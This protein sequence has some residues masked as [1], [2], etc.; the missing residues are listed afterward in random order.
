MSKTICKY[1]RSERI[2]SIAG[3]C[4]CLDNMGHDDIIVGGIYTYIHIGMGTSN[5]IE[6]ISGDYETEGNW[7]KYRGTTRIL[8]IEMFQI[9]SVSP[10]RGSMVIGDSPWINVEE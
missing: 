2:P 5:C 7:D 10:N 6:I 4:R 1:C 9:L 3:V 8:P